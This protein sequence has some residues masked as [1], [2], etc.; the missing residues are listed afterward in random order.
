[1]VVR[2]SSDAI[3]NCGAAD[4]GTQ[5]SKPFKSVPIKGLVGKPSPQEAPSNLAVL[6]RDILPSAVLAC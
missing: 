6:G 1:M 5:A 4:L 2:V 3:E